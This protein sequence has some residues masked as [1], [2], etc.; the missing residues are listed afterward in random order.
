MLFAESDKSVRPTRAEELSANAGEG[1]RATFN[2]RDE[3]KSEE[4]PEAFSA[5]ET[6]H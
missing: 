3:A 6:S 4:M 2:S 1:A 5:E